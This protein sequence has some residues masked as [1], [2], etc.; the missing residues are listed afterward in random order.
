MCT[1]FPAE[2]WHRHD[3]R[4]Y[5]DHTRCEWVCPADEAAAAEPAADEAAPIP[6][7]AAPPAGSAGSS[8]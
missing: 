6:P 8:R 2:P 5:W 3:Q 4:C 7:T 1:S